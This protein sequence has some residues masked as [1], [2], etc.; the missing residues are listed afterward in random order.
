MSGEITEKGY[1]A[2]YQNF[3]G[4]NTTL[5]VASLNRQDGKFACSAG[6]G[7][8]INF[9]DKSTKLVVEGKGSYSLSDNIS[10]NAR[11]RN[12]LSSES[13]TSQL[14]LATEVKTKL[15]ENTTAY[16]DVYVAPK[17]NYE[18]GKIKTDYGA[19]AGISQSLGHN[20]TL[21]CEVQKYKDDW[22]INAIFGWTF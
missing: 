4:S 3:D 17:I 14:R 2:T 11:L 16:G 21:S 12:M 8:G 13:N 15:G 6:I 7:Y 20:T 9:K 1:I 22:G 18:T 5:G 19:F 10:F